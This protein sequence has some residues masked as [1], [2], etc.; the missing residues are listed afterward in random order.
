MFNLTD[1]RSHTSHRVVSIDGDA[2]H[3]D[4]PCHGETEFHVDDFSRADLGRLRIG[5][6]VRVSAGVSKCWH[7]TYRFMRCH[8][9]IG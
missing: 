2:I 6:E 4:T 8:V 9:A 3:V 5:A 7:K 1:V